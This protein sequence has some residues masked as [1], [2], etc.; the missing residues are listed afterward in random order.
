MQLSHC[1]HFFWTFYAMNEGNELE[2]IFPGWNV[3]ASCDPWR[4]SRSEFKHCIICILYYLY[5]LQIRKN[6]YENIEVEKWCCR[7]EGGFWLCNIMIFMFCIYKGLLKI[8]LQKF[9]FVF[10]CLLV[11][12]FF[13][14]SSD[15]NWYSL[16]VL[17]IYQR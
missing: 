5:A 14:T 7:E 2:K 10:V 1:I 9:S 17:F 12:V 11:V 13:F 4:Q 6:A 3:T 15:L 16:S 8:P